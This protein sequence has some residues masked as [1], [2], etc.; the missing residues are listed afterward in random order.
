MV[1]NFKLTGDE[2]KMI[3]TQLQTFEV[4]YEEQR[5]QLI[6]QFADDNPEIMRTDDDYDDVENKG[7]FQDFTEEEYTKYL[8]ANRKLYKDASLQ[9]DAIFS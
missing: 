9:K 7:V 3:K 8:E 5:D 2:K 1:N 6:T 4:W